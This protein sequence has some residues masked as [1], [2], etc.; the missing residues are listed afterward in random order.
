MKYRGIR[1]RLK[2]QDWSQTKPIPQNHKECEIESKQAT[3]KQWK[4]RKRNKRNWEPN[5]TRK[6]ERK[7]GEINKKGSN[8]TPKK[9]RKIEEMKKKALGQA[10]GKQRKLRKRIRRNWGNKGVSEKFCVQ[11]CLFLKN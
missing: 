9:K 5:L 10:T 3:G 4:L 1:G 6:T 7:T 8:L 2:T 11:P